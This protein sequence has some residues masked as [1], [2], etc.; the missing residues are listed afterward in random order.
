MSAY[1]QFAEE[2]NKIDAY[3]KQQYVITGVREG[4]S[5][6]WLELKHPGGDQ[7]SLLVETADARK[8]FANLLIRQARIP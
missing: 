1:E 6:D 5:G 4:L 2:K 7:A 3:M 8:Y